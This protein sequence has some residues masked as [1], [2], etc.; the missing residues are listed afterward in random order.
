M[1]HAEEAVSKLVVAGGD[2]AVDL[3][4]AEHAL[5]AIA[6]LVERPII[7]DLHTAVCPTRNDGLDLSFGQI[8]TDG[9]GIIAFVGKEG[10]GCLFW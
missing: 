7:L 1:D 9:I 10:I 6:L 8:G 3:E 4:V 2:G 5:D